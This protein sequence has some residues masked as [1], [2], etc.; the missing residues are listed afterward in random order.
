MKMIDY[1]VHEFRYLSNLRRRRRSFA[2]AMWTVQTIHTFEGGHHRDKWLGTL[3]L[4]LVG[5]GLPL[6][7][8][9]F[10]RDDTS[11]AGNSYPTR[12][13]RSV[14]GTVT[15]SRS[16][17]VRR[18][19]SSYEFLLCKPYGAV[20]LVLCKFFAPFGNNNNN[21]REGPTASAQTLLA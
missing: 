21:N 15:V 1:H 14:T 20:H 9:V 18:R 16:Q 11:F 2:D 7:E 13:T 19:S 6:T 8:L 3:Q 10:D 17:S 12:Y 4:L 5:P